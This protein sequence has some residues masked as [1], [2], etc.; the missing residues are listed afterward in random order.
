[1]FEILKSRIAE[2]ASSFVKAEEKEIELEL[3]MQTKLTSIL[4]KEVEIKERD[5]AT[6]LE[7]LMLSLL[8]AD[9]AHETAERITGIIKEGLVGK[10]VEKNTIREFVQE[11]VRNSLLS[12]TKKYE[13]RIEK[14]PYV[15]LFIGPNG[16]GKTTTIAKFAYMLGRKGYRCIIAASDTFRAAAIEQIE[17]HGRRLGVGIIRHS[18][19]SDPAAIAFDAIERAKARGIDVVLI[20]TAGRQETNRNLLEEMRKIARVAKPD[21]KIF[22]GEALAGNAVVS[23]IKELDK[24]VGVDAAIL[25]KIDCDVKGGTILSVCDAGFPIAYI[26]TGQEYDALVEFNPEWFVDALLD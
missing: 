24:A 19:G 16:A 26:G 3:S 1:M 22:V 6:Y 8:E 7:K 14:S 9:V 20:D 11:V 23:Q 10:R 5:V 25:T 17:E 4:S 12:I 15:I 2:F 21:L 13:L 18:Y